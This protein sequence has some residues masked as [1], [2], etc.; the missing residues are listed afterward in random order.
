MNLRTFAAFGLLSFS[1]FAQERVDLR[2]FV[3]A[4]AQIVARIQGPGRW[5]DAFGPTRLGALMDSSLLAPWRREMAGL[6]EEEMQSPYALAMGPELM[7]HLSEDYRGE[8]VVT[9][10]L[11]PPDPSAPPAPTPPAEDDDEEMEFVG[12][13]DGAEPRATAMLTMTPAEGID[14]AALLAGFR[15][16]DEDE[17]AKHNGQVK[18]SDVV[19]GKHTFQLVE[20]LDAEDAGF[21]MTQAELVDGHLVLFV[22]NDIA[23]NAPK[24]LA[25]SNRATELPPAAPLSIHVDIEKLWSLSGVDT[26]LAEA[27]ELMGSEGEPGQRTGFRIG[28][29]TFRCMTA[30]DLTFGADGKAVVL[31]TSLATRGK[32]LGLLTPF[33]AGGTPSKLLRY[34]PAQETSFSVF[35]FDLMSMS[36]W[37][38]LAAEV[39]GEE[40][41]EVFAE[42]ARGFFE[43][44][45]VRL[46]EDLLDHLGT[47]VLV[48]GG[49]Q[50]LVEDVL[51]AMKEG[52]EPEPDA[53]FGGS[54]L[55]LSLRDGRAFGESLEKM[56][57]ANGL[58]AARR[59]Q[60]YQDVDIHEL[61]LGGVLS[62]E[63]AVTDDALWLV[64]GRG[65]GRD[66]LRAAL[67]ARADKNPPA[68]PAAGFAGLPT[69]WTG[70]R[71]FQ[72]TAW[73]RVLAGLAELAPM[74]GEL[75]ESEQKG[76]EML[77]GLAK[78]L[79]GLDAAEILVGDYTSP[80]GWRTVYRW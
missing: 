54:C 45:K 77:Q 26:L 50:Q 16:A 56:I 71:R 11:T 36:R 3:S 78:E 68:D 63:Y 7:R 48:L 69:G 27:E 10:L 40:A 61:S 35:P 5:K 14:L 46:R 51:T 37:I 70:V 33:L 58:R 64:P 23:T 21:A 65:T 22:G 75:D 80:R 6:F 20:G 30:F 73:L 59:T 29:D 76:L 28:L 39:E 4:D 47:D 15:R 53:L 1:L 19:V 2:R 79:K 34:V 66:K 72:L 67:D 44:N 13:F 17:F 41:A 43:A 12:G 49:L 32:D 74:L 9:M 55:A 42:A 25:E 8:F 60:K 24:L 57:R 62:I 38:E 18:R 52:Q 31:D